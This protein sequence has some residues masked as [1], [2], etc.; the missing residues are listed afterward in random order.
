GWDSTQLLRIPGWKNHKPEY[1][2][3]KTGAAPQGKLVIRSG[4]RYLVDEFN[5]LPEV[6][7][8]AVVVEVLE[9]ELAHTDRH[10]VWGRVRLRVSSRVRELV[11]AREA[12][13][14]RS[15]V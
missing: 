10:E 3:K 12:T 14:D 6:P 5:D 9:G 13:G 1:R 4:R 7:Q 11:S 15:D 2:N 8:V